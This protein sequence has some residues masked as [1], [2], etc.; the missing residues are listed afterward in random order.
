MHLVDLALYGTPMPAPDFAALIS[1]AK[2]GQSEAIAALIEAV[3]RDLRAFLATYAASPAMLEEAHTATWIQVRKELAACPPSSQ[4]VIWIR[5]RAIAILKNLLEEESGT[6]IAARDGLRHL[7]VQDGLEG[8]QALVSPSNEGAA[9]L[10]QRYAAL[11]EADQLLLSR[12]Y[13]DG[14]NLNSL[15]SELGGSDGDIA[16]R[17]CRCRGSLHWRSTDA[18]RRPSDDPQVAIAIDLML[19]GTLDAVGR[20]A[21][22][23]TLMK[24]LGRAA[25]FTRQVRIDLMLQAVFG[26]YTPEQARQ[27][28]GTL[29]K[30]EHKR[31][32]ESSLL[33]VVAPPRVPVGSGSELRQT[34]DRI[35]NRQA[36][37]P[38]AAA[39]ITTTTRPVPRAGGGSRRRGS[40]DQNLLT[41]APGG[42]GNRQTLMIGG[43]I[44]VIGLMALAV[45]WGRGGGAARTLDDPAVGASSVATVVA[46]QGGAHLLHKDIQSPA[47]V[48]AALGASHGLDSGRGETTVE[49]S[50]VARVVL[51]P[52]TLVTSFA[53]LPD[54]T[55]Q[56]HLGRGSLQINV[57]AQPGLEVRTAQ[58]RVTFGIGRGVVSSEADRTLVQAQGGSITVV[59]T[60]GG[61]A[62]QV[63]PEKRVEILA[64]APP[65]LLQPSS[66]VRGINFGGPPVTIDRK[67]WLSQREAMSAG[68]SLGT[69]TSIAPQAMFTGAGLDFDRKTMLDTGLVGSGGTVQF[70]QVMPAGDYDL[71]LWLANTASLDE[72]HLTL[73][74]NGTPLKLAGALLKRDTWAQLGPLPIRVGQGRMELQ[75][76][77]Q[78]NAR[79]SGMA[80]EGP[81]GETVALPAAVVITSPIDAATFYGNQKITLRAEVMGLVKAVQFFS[82]DKLLGEALKEP[83]SVTVTR[84]E[85]GEQRIVARAINLVGEPSESLPLSFSVIPAFGTGSILLERWH[86]LPGDRIDHGKNDPKVTKPPQLANDLK[87]FATK[88]DW[89]EQY[90]CRIRGYVHP[91]LTGEYVFWIVTDDEGE[92]LLSTNENAKEAIRIAHNPIAVGSRE[93]TKTPSQQ[94]RS[95]HLVA[96]KRYFIELRY[97]EHEGGDHGACGWKLPNGT[98][99]RP[100]PGVHLSPYKP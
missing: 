98:M 100:I 76:G 77:G 20:Q 7:V 31:R 95:I 93:W 91:P 64:G 51:N 47:R 71:T 36:G 11:D 24:D 40:S 84:P 10:N 37:V 42:D 25:G 49:F 16:H 35:G 33:Q 15:A 86:G 96:G 66:F 14:A 79:V 74:I 81:G 26:A 63:L 17:L 53:A 89:G 70:T 67:R 73:T 32:N 18:D 45:L 43:A 29:A 61:G 39:A 8:L 54:R 1:K 5:Q 62:M 46:T 94:S 41:R 9:L 19:G 65:R 22:G 3:V 27:L 38:E 2:S 88:V 72:S 82:G 83:Y 99:E 12:R 44:A 78:G 28:A 97:K 56:V 30:I 80:L 50:G 6:A 90:Y 13:G 60:A 4:A 21:L 59:S 23:T 48:G 75:L 69:G 87:E 85:P 68:L 55:G 52:S 92:L 34:N 58:G 57:T